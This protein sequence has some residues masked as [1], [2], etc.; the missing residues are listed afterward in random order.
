M[1]P[2]EAPARSSRICVF[3]TSGLAPRIA[4]GSSANVAAFTSSTLSSAMPRS[5]GRAGSAGAGG[6]TAGVPGTGAAGTDGC[7]TTGGLAGAGVAGAAGAAW[8]GGVYGFGPVGCSGAGGAAGAGAAGTVGCAGA[9]AAGWAVTGGGG[10]T[11][12]VTGTP[13]RGGTAVAGGTGAGGGAGSSAR[14]S[15][16]STSS[17]KVL[18]WAAAPNGAVAVRTARQRAK[19]LRKRPSPR[20]R[21]AKAI[22][23]LPITPTEML[24]QALT[25]SP[26]PSPLLRER[27]AFGVS[28][29]SGEGTA[30]IGDR[31]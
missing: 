31:R 10:V 21:A 14:F 4:A 15:A 25:I 11:G 1:T 18:S 13:M 17:S 7:T 26:P 12:G 2:G 3:R 24:T 6:A 19:N 5:G 30:A 16:S 29:R 22:R 23:R 8:T 27:V 28:R 20:N 9:G